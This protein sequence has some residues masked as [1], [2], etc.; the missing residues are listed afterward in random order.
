MNDYGTTAALRA[1]PCEG[2][3]ATTNNDSS[4]LTCTTTATTGKEKTFLP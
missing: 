1:A 4:S 3:G 2:A